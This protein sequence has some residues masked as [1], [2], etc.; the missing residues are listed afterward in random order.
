MGMRLELRPLHGFVAAVEAAS[1]TAAAKGATLQF[2][3]SQQIRDPEVVHYSWHAVPVD[4]PNKIEPEVAGTLRGKNRRNKAR[5]FHSDSF[6]I[7]PQAPQSESRQEGAAT[8]VQRVKGFGA[9]GAV[10]EPSARIPGAGDACA[11]IER[12]M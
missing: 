9:A 11:V 5:D 10:P 12:M 6:G 3:L 2:S 1:P 4:I 8:A 7:L